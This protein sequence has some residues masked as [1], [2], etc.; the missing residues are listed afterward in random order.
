MSDECRIAISGIG[1]E[2][3]QG[4]LK[5]L[6]AEQDT[7]FILGLDHQDDCVGFHMVDAYETTPDCIRDEFIPTL[8]GFLQKHRIQYYFSGV[9]L[10]VA[11][12]SA[13]RT[14]I[15][16]ETACRLLLPPKAITDVATDKL[17]T[18]DWLNAHGLPYPKTW[19][20]KDLNPDVLPNDMAF[21]LI[22]K[23]R[24]G[25]G[26]RGIDKLNDTTALKAH[27]AAQHVNSEDGASIYGTYCYQAYL[28]GPEYT[29]ELLFDDE[30]RLVDTLCTE[31]ILRQ[32]RTICA[33]PILDGRFD[34]FLQDVGHA[35]SGMRG[36]INVQFRINHTGLPTIF[37]INP[38]YS[39][40]T[41]MRVE[42]G[43][44]SPLRYIKH[45]A[46]GASIKP[47]A[48]RHARVYRHFT[49]LTVDLS[50][51]ANGHNI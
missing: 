46:F 9:D 36:A 33:W 1:A 42:L 14:Q 12:L 48:I 7:F 38:R 27:L 34:T 2:A 10:E 39:G 20:Q 49:E 24:Q 44:N 30:Q 40:S 13:H 21:P 4:I 35:L 3:A 31:R 45:T 11:Y 15:E 47:A 8:I 17:K 43:F 19:D 28:D 25:Y 16:S 5:A 29:A 51:T 41:G 37:E 32:G 26:S 50:D 22:A 23:P 18:S 6:R